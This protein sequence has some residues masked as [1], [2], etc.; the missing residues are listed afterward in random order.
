MVAINAIA[1]SFDG[2][3]RQALQV[4]LVP[5]QDF[6]S[7]ASLNGVAWRLSDVMGPVF[8]G[9]LLALPEYGLTLCYALNFISFFALFV[10]IFRMKP[11]QTA[12][13][14]DQPKNFKEVISLIKDGLRFVNNTPVIRH[15][16]WIDFWATFLSGAE[17]LLPAFA[18]VILGLGT[19][20][21]GLLA[22][23]TG[24]GALVAATG[25]TWM[26]TIQNQGKLV[27]SMIALYGLAT[28]ALGF[29]PNL[30]VAMACLA[31]VGASDMISTVMRQTIRQLATPDELR[32]RMNATSSLFHISGPQL[33]DFE[34][35]AVAHFVGERASIKLGG[36][37]CLLVA[38]NWSRAKSLVSYKHQ[39][40]HSN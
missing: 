27:V 25:L 36:A 37:L 6:P 32:G 7:A 22:G 35:G 28:F 14:D 23:A 5:L 33:G 4:G 16:M 3:A 26:P 20:G 11:T 15:A 8:A 30:A 2:P 34:S 18:G 12:P 21:Y 39:E 24:M 10:V 1:R 19:E 40:P 38:L 13:K 29:A 17:A 31:V 9:I